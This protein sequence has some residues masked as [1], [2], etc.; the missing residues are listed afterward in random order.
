M[1]NW[2][3]Y[4]SFRNQGDTSFELIRC[5]D[6]ADYG[7]GIKEVAGLYG[8]TLLHIACWNGWLGMVKQLIEKC[9]C[10]PEVKDCGKQ[11]PLHYACRQGSLDIIQYLIQEH[12]CDVN[13]FTTD[14]WTP[15]YYACRYGHLDVVKYLV[16]I[17]DVVGCI[18]Q[19]IVLQMICEYG[20]FNTLLYLMDEQGFTPEKIS[21]LISVA[22]EHGFMEIVCYLCRNLDP[23]NFENMDLKEH[24]AL[25]I[26]CCCNNHLDILKRLNL[27]SRYACIAEISDKFSMSG[28]HYACQEGHTD[29]VKY[30]V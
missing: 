7:I 10:D 21:S 12:Q 23:D 24:K 3:L 2:T 18:D 14:Q 6:K 26:F 5:F 13:A 25:F 28:L 16:Q 29:V 4:W 27:K 9:E 17:P 8:D 15:F 1:A 11:T 19:Q 20:Y 30:L 22:C